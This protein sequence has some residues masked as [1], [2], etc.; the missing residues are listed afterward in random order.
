MRYWHRNYKGS[1][2][3]PCFQ[4][5]MKV[6]A[7]PFVIP[8]LSHI[9]FHTVLH[10]KATINAKFDLQ[11]LVSYGFY[12][13]EVRPKFCHLVHKTGILILLCT[14]LN[15]ISRWVLYCKISKALLW[16]KEAY[17]DK[18]LKESNRYFCFINWRRAYKDFMYWEEETNILAS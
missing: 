12:L 7:L 6:L 3:K 14:P 2:L 18:I 17:E 11:T 5:I 1:K 13:L 4:I 15:L 9:A 16:L 10:F 8:I